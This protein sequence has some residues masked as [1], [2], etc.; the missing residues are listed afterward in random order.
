MN[1]GKELKKRKI[2]MDISREEIAAAANINKCT[3]SH[4]LNNKP[5]S[6]AS[7]GKIVDA[8]GGTIVIEWKAPF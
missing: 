7:L 3:V 2:D 6:M 1:I 5:V 8:M 4:A